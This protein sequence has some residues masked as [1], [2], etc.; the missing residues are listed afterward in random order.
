[1]STNHDLLKEAYVQIRGLKAELKKRETISH[2]PIAIIGVG[3]R[4]PKGA[5]DLNSFWRVLSAGEDAVCEVPANRYDI[6]S[7]FDSDFSTPGKVGTRWGSFLDQI[8]G[9]DPEFFGITP[10]EAHYMD[11]QQ[12]LLLEVAWEALEEAGIKP[13][14]LSGSRTGIFVGTMYN[15][16]QIR[17]LADMGREGIN[18]YFGI[19]TT[20]SACA[21]R[22]AYTF[23]FQGPCMAVDTAC[24]SSLVSVHLA[25]QS[26]RSGEC[27]LALA[28]GVNV[29]L[30]PE[31]TINLTK[32]HMMSPTGRCRTFDAAADGYVRGEG[33]GLIALKRLSDAL[34]QGDRILGLIRGSAVNQDGRSSGITAP[35]RL[36]QQRLMQE[37]LQ[38]AGISSDAVGYIECHGTGTPLGDPIEVSAIVDV[39]NRAISAGKPLAIGSV[40]TNYGHLESAAGICGLIKALLIVKQ[41]TLPPHLHLQNLNPHIDF[42]GTDVNI[43][44][45]LISGFSGQ[46]RQIAA[47]SAFGFVGTNAHLILE[48]FTEAAVSKTFSAHRRLMTLSAKSQPGLNELVQH[49][50]EHLVTHNSNDDFLNLCHTTNARRD[51]FQHRLFVS[52]ETAEEAIEALRDFS[53]ARTETTA[54]AN[55]KTVFAFTGQGS[56]YPGMG[57]E[58]AD[59]S[60]LF[61]KT[62]EQCD[63]VLHPTI[64]VSLLEIMWRDQKPEEFMATGLVQVALFSIEYSLAQLFIEWD[65]KPHLLVGHSLG[66]YVA[67][68]V[69]GM[70]SLEEGLRLVAERGRLMHA[71]PGDGAMAAVF[72]SEENVRQLLSEHRSSV[73]VAAVNRSGETTV[74]GSREALSQWLEILKRLGIEY[75]LLRV[76]H[77]FHSPKM[78]LMT[79]DFRRVLDKVHFNKPQIPI[80]SNLNGQLIHGNEVLNP[81]Y[82]I[83]QTLSP[84]RFADALQTIEKEA[85]DIYLEIGAHPALLESITDATHQRAVTLLPTLR[86]GQ[87][88]WSQILHAVGILYQKGVSIDWELFE[89]PHAGRLSSIPHY[90]FQRERYWYDILSPDESPKAIVSEIV[91]PKPSKSSTTPLAEETSNLAFGLMFFAAR[92]ENSTSVGKY[93]LVIQS[94]R[95]ADQNGFSSVWVPE[96]HFTSMG[97]LYPNPAVLHAAVARETRH[98]CLM[99]GSLVAPLH[100]P[101]RIFE[102]WSMVDNLSNGRAGISLASGWNPDDFAFAPD[103]YA[104]RHNHLFETV[105]I[106]RKLWRGE[107]IGIQNGVGATSLVHPMPTPIQ[108]E[109]P[110]WIT[111]A[112]NPKT[113]E[114]AGQAGANLLTHLLDQDIGDLREKI[115]IY[116]DARSHAGWD[117]STG[118]V[119]IMVHTFLGED[120]ETVRRQVKEPFCRYLKASRGLLKGLA[121]ARGRGVNLDE[122]SEVEFGEFIEF[123]FERF[124]NTRA[125]IGTPDTAEKLCH[126]LKAAGVNEIACLLDFG[127][128]S[129]EILSSLPH[130]NELR[131]RIRQANG[132]RETFPPA[133]TNRL[134]SSSFSMPN[135]WM[136][137][138]E[139]EKIKAPLAEALSPEHEWLIIQ[140]KGN[141][142]EELCRALIERGAD[143][144]IVSSNSDEWIPVALGMKG[145]KRELV[146]LRALDKTFHLNADP[147]H[148]RDTLGYLIE[149][150][151]EYIRRQETEGQSSPARIRIITRGA[152]HVRGD[153]GADPIQAA[154]WGFARVLP[155]EHPRQWGGLIDL[156]PSPLTDSSMLFDALV[157]K[158]DEDKMAIRNKE[159]F[160]ERLVRADLNSFQ[161]QPLEICE[162]DAYLITGGLGGLG[163]ELSDWLAHQGARHLVILGRSEVPARESWNDCE[164][165]RR[166][167]LRRLATISRSGCEIEYA[168]VD[169]N[170][171]DAVS[172]FAATYQTS[173]GAPISGIFHAAGTWK[174]T[175]IAQ[176]D[177]FT[178]HEVLAPKVWGTVALVKS[179]R[180]SLKF[181][182]L[183]SSFSSILPAHGQANY[184]AANAF[185]DAMAHELS[186]GD[187]RAQSI[188]WGPWSD[189]GFAMSE[190]GRRAHERLES[191]G[192]NRFTPRQGLAI[193][194]EISQRHV[195][196]SGA[197]LVDW[198][199]LSEIDPT[200]AASPMLSRISFSHKS[201]PLSRS[202]GSV[203]KTI[204]MV[205]R[206]A[207]S[208][209][210]LE[211]PLSEM[212]LDSL[213]AVEIKNRIKSQLG[214]DIPLV[215]FLQGATV[216]QLEQWVQQESRIQE[217]LEEEF[218]V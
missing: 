49:Y 38:R 165:P 144:H 4:F 56:Q 217:N 79:E 36:A 111:A 187:L 97:S 90:P 64:G 41:G 50:A 2:E 13:S 68:C 92:E 18:A 161:S 196:Q 53:R 216:T 35:N 58:L 9:F 218:V 200:L 154:L 188:N 65:V 63:K 52:S 70:F 147:G 214:V 81:D 153:R 145:K 96:R 131:K 19:G 24:S 125:L 78:E 173:H 110:L 99:A 22:L 102:D 211:R 88:D 77:A 75:R 103:Q 212:G 201:S 149:P 204:S 45:Q 47:V 1:M 162:D 31:P 48:N 59:A 33:C 166:E 15:E 105:D 141:V 69:A 39:Y 167:A 210:E 46:N 171:P 11:P 138:I 170:D 112:G 178:L 20:P 62:L 83:Q 37:A 160:V 150:L 209:L 42:R 146:D 87:P 34:N 190:K 32:A 136:Y 119:S 108:R 207:E 60:P 23:G 72:S 156:D 152:Q 106:L 30:T 168:R 89:Q 130:L 85:P 82:W 189:V 143:A 40:K 25:C 98:I 101:I 61:R 100:H 118:R 94:A 195:T 12:R 180:N 186:S 142:A 181:I 3:L 199:R 177:S 191:F 73:V 193:F 194:E 169:L 202:G 128:G 55:P 164:H 126:E 21:G 116:R 155:L 197:L 27:G 14:S 122:L 5:H 51:H 86:R 7:V 43:P 114:R 10:T 163:L 127:P 182:Q 185:L 157:A 124:Y 135:N 129:Q 76:S 29:L 213:M 176:L 133:I 179:F 71:I 66:E 184:A 203:K 26:L 205:M 16:F 8:D 151:T 192:M 158:S 74:S 93:D 132:H 172:T 95:F 215:R 139:W 174:D 107:P 104:D 137:E 206:I 17:Q 80:A 148:L 109:L 159:L 115:A 113:F 198:N 123:L 44:T 6:N 54:L 121:H 84:V 140:D 67:A 120:I 208:K 183:F 134:S 175:A 117:P 28:G 57:R 91:E